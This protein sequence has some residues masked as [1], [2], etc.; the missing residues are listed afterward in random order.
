MCDGASARNSKCSSYLCFG[1]FLDLQNQ[2]WTLLP[3]SGFCKIYRTEMSNINILS[4]KQTFSVESGISY[5]E[6]QF[7]TLCSQNSY[8]DTNA[9]CFKHHFLPSLLPTTHRFTER[10]GLGSSKTAERKYLNKAFHLSKNTD[11]PMNLSVLGLRI[12]K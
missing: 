2:N 9:L 7:F 12:P 8:N 5:A 11:R 3:Q 6:H 4:S 10:E 1:V